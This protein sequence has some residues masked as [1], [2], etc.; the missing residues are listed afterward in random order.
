MLER[1]E[2][3]EDELNIIRYNF[4]MT[5]LHIESEKE[6]TE[7]MILFTK[8]VKDFMDDTNDRIESIEDAYVAMSKN[9]SIT[10][11]TIDVMNRNIK[12]IT[13]IFTQLSNK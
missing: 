8:I 5:S 7:S 12:H 2:K 1:I 13:E 10:K 4:E 6:K 9:M 3:I 11:E